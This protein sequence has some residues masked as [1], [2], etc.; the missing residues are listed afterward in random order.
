MTKLILPRDLPGG[1][2]YRR[3]A[4]RPQPFAHSLQHIGVPGFACYLTYV[5]LCGLSIVRKHIHFCAISLATTLS[6]ANV[7]SFVLSLR[8]C[9]SLSFFLSRTFWARSP[10]RGASCRL[11]HWQAAWSC[12][13]W[14]RRRTHWISFKI[15]QLVN[16][17]LKGSPRF[18]ISEK[19]WFSRL[20]SSPHA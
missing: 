4:I 13:H 10:P 19:S 6:S 15:Y 12:R 7:I 17:P 14:P 16:P 2:R 5:I 3:P 8:P 20:R 18:R 1:E 9:C 11:W